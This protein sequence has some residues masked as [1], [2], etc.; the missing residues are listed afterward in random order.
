MF[1]H[2]FEAEKKLAA[3][4]SDSLTEYELW[5]ELMVSL[6]HVVIRIL[7]SWHVLNSKCVEILLEGMLWMDSDFR[8]V[9]FQALTSD[10]ESSQVV[11]RAQI[12]ANFVPPVKNIDL[13]TDN[14]STQ[15]VIHRT[16]T[17][18]AGNS[19][20]SGIPGS[21]NGSSIQEDNEDTD[22]PNSSDSNVDA[23]DT[24]SEEDDDDASDTVN[25]SEII[26]TE[27]AEKG[28]GEQT[29]S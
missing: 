21:L 11:G 24:D 15:S 19:V 12:T 4:L 26:A 2:L 14:E 5:A 28:D 23:S 20:A 17:R 22:G 18:S 1:E 16:S 8:W 3:R 13:D 9:E 6:A 27:K 29:A 25:K 10:N 7:I